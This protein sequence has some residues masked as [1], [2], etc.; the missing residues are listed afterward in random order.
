MDRRHRGELLSSACH[1]PLR[2][3]FASLLPVPHALLDKDDLHVLSV[4][5]PIIIDASD[6]IVEFMP[7]PHL[8]SFD[9][10]RGV[11]TAE[12]EFFTK[13]VLYAKAPTD[14]A[15]VGRGTDEVHYLGAVWDQHGCSLYVPVHD[16]RGTPLIF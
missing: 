3:F 13:F 14:A 15:I 9:V 7:E 8:R 2:E 6:D 1:T 16:L 5:F 12:S 4:V 11:R 10:L